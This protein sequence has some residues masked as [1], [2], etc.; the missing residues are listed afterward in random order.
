MQIKFL[1]PEHGLVNKVKN[2]LL[3]HV[4]KEKRQNILKRKCDI[5]VNPEHLF[6]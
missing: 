1:F 4:M 2:S 3:A 6:M 5:I